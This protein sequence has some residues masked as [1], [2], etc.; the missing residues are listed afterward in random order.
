MQN[1]ALLGKLWWKFRDLKHN[2]WKKVKKFIHGVDGCL[3]NPTRARCGG[4][5]GS[6]EKLPLVLSENKLKFKEFFQ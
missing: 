3:N 5:W 1:F 4:C 6:I 2:I